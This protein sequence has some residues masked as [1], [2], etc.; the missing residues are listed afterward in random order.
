MPDPAIAYAHRNN[1]YHDDATV[2]PVPVPCTGLP[3]YQNLAGDINQPQITV[4]PIPHEDPDSDVPQRWIQLWAALDHTTG[5]ELIGNVYWRVYHPDGSSKIQVHGT[6]IGDP[7]GR[8]TD[9]PIYIYNGAG[10]IVGCC[11]PGT[12]EDNDVQFGTVNSA[13]RLFDECEGLGTSSLEGSMFHA[14]GNVAHA[15]GQIENATI[16]DIPDGL[17]YK[18]TQAEKA[19]YYAKFTVDK[20]QPCGRYRIEAYAV[21]SNTRFAP[22]MT[23]YIDIVCFTY[24]NLDFNGLAWGDLINGTSNKINGDNVWDANPNEAASADHPGTI[25]NGGNH[26]MGIHLKYS[27]MTTSDGKIIDKFD[28]CFAREFAALVCWGTS[29]TLSGEFPEDI[30]QADE[31][32]GFGD[33]SYI[34]PVGSNDTNGL[35]VLSDRWKGGWAQVLCAN[36]TGKID[37]SVWPRTFQEQGSYTGTVTIHSHSVH[38][39]FDPPNTARHEDDG[40]HSFLCD[41]DQ[42]LHNPVS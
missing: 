22:V 17:V 1:F 5:V 11:L 4:M 36:D 19:I 3:G 37:F 10:Q 23:N 7:D 25:H 6:R 24:M 33:P 31:W 32:V 15:T 40:Q 34:D 16:D 30:I 13:S 18:C 26:P 38:D 42:E 21:D 20:D 2:D 39:P 27:E 14:A 41:Q 12:D 29:T 28:A 35:E 8:Y 9:G